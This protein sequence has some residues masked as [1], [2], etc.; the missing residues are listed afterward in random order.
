MFGLMQDRPLMISSIITHAARQHGKA[1][2][3]S[4]NLDGSVSRSN[5]VE[6]ERRA[7]RMARALATLG[8]GMGDRV[9]TVALNSCRHVEL[10]YAISGMGAVCHTINPRLSPDDFAYVVNHAQDQVIFAEAVFLPLIAAVAPA[11]AGHVRAVVVMAGRAGMPSLALPAGMA[12]LCYEDLIDGADD[13]FAWPEFDE[14]TAASLCYTSGT[15]G[16]PKGVLYSHRSTLLHA[17]AANGGDVIGITAVDRVLPV[18]PMFHVNAWGIPY[19]APMAGAA[20]ILPG[21]HL[22]GAS[23]AGLINAETVTI[24]CGVPTVWLGLLQHLRSSGERIDSVR[25][26]TVG[27]SAVPRSMTEAFGTEYGVDLGQGWGMT[28]MS[29]V[30]TYC[31]PNAANAHLTGEELLRLK[32]KQ[33]R[34]LWGV[35]MRIVG[36]DGQALPWDGVAFGLL[37]VRGPWICSAYFGE[38][39]GSALDA[40]GW[41]ST[42]DI[43]TIDADGFMEITDRAKDVIKSGGEWISSVQ[44]ENI[45]AG[46][47]DVAEA[48]I[49]AARHPKWDERPLLI[50]TAKAGREIDPATVMDVFEGKI[51]GWWKP[52][53][54]VV[55]ADLPH[56]ATGKVH[57]MVLRD[58]YKDHLIK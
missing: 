15:T 28:E 32:E 6:V 17:L 37:Q 23:I 20:L 1:E 48:A 40:E 31:Q 24:S 14:R 30:G 56:T 3:V 8:V 52:D 36:D 51:A 53:A 7:R 34:A 45:A 46:H 22:D 21:R 49:I 2:V 54:V 4:K 55:V 25:R 42:G 43:A 38:E 16:R 9:A 19:A 11:I 41:F 18:V 10:Y 44:L 39:A 57:K 27:G 50:V 12:L 29:P 47:P 5:Y 58:Q 26:L 35:E 33:G 13:A